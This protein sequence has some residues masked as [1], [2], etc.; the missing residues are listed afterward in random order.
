VFKVWDENL[1]FIRREDGKK[2]NYIFANPIII[3]Y[4][5]WEKKCMKV[6]F[7]VNLKSLVLVKSIAYCVSH[8]VVKASSFDVDF[9]LPHFV[10]IYIC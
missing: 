1:A 10:C 5:R 9:F 2:P 4:T 3:W 6:G 8:E 7:L